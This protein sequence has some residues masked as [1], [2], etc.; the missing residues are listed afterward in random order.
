[1]TKSLSAGLANHVTLETTSLA[2]CWKVERT[3]GI[4]FGFTDHDALI[5]YDGVD[6]KAETGF[7]RSN[8]KTAGDLSIDQLDIQGILNSGEITEADIR[9]RRYNNAEIYF[10]LINWADTSQGI[11]KLR[12][13]LIGEITLQQNLFVAEL[14]GL[15]Q[16]LSRELLEEYTP[17]CQADFG[18]S[19]CGFDSSTLEQES[20]VISV[21]TDR[22]VFTVDP[23]TGS[24]DAGIDWSL[25]GLPS[26]GLD[27]ARIEWTSGSNNGL[28]MEVKDV[29]PASNTIELYLKAPF[30]ISPG[31]TFKIRP[32]CD[33]RFVTCKF[34]GQQKRFRGFPDVPGQDAFLQYPDAKA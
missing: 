11:A 31:D 7:T 23:S 19:R 6:Y 8:I 25:A 12:R 30:T 16:Y 18:D 2:F 26:Y 28:F 1:M 4:V 5:Q 13:G 22:L 15:N 32:G 27:L 21:T 24:G 3:D 33:K 10:F 17:E 14:Q 34:F 9:A 20:T 29:T